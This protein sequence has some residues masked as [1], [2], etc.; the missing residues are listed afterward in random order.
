[1]VSVLAIYSDDLS[2]NPTLA[3]SLFGKFVFENS[4]NKQKRQKYDH[5]I[6]QLSIK[7]NSKCIIFLSQN[8]FSQIGEIN[9]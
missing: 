2:S 4:E 9:I 7:Y 1:M 5:R 8:R 6:I 3:N